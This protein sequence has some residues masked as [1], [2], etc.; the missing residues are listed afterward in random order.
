MPVNGNCP[1]TK[2][3]PS[4]STAW[5]NGATGSGAPAIIWNMGAF[6][7]AHLCISLYP[8]LSTRSCAKTNSPTTIPLVGGCGHFI[9]RHSLVDGRRVDFQHF[10]IIRAIEFV[11][12]DACR[13]Q[14][15]IASVEQTFPLAFVHEL[16]PAF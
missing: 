16:N 3:Q 8:V 12:D 7:L 15:A 4:C 1:V 10:E 11:M 6:I 9:H 14:D 13:L 5:L 2:T